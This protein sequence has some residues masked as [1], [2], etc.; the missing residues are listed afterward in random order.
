ME[1]RPF[2]ITEAFS[3]ELREAD[4]AELKALYGLD[5]RPAL[6][7]ACTLSHPESLRTVATD[8]GQL[9][10]IFGSAIHP[11]DSRVGCVWMVGSDL[12]TKHSKEFLKITPDLVKTASEPYEIVYNYIDMRNTTHLRWLKY[13]GF[14]F[15]HTSQ[16][17]SHDGSPFQFFWKFNEHKLISED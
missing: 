8:E 4:K 9:V 10:A 5:P 14:T 12:I 3:I 13:A 11:Q 1:I 16:T 2:H 6:G 15:G 17:V 7:L